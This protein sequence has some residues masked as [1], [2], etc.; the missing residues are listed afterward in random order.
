MVDLPSQQK[1][2]LLHKGGSLVLSHS[3]TIPKPGP[4][5]F[6]I[7]IKATALNPGDW[8]FNKYGMIKEFPAVLGVDIAGDVTALGEGVTK[9]KIGD[10][11]L[12]VCS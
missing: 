7:K 12:V 5:Q 3:E 11:V 8:K 9:F 6:L 4:G 2:L 1:A 10:R